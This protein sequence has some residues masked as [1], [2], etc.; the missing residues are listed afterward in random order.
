MK[1]KYPE[2][3]LRIAYEGLYQ[4][5]DKRF[6]L[7]VDNAN[8]IHFVQGPSRSSLNINRMNKHVKYYVGDT[9]FEM[10]G[11]YIYIYIIKNIIYNKYIDKKSKGGQ[12]D[13]E[14]VV[15]SIFEQSSVNEDDEIL[16]F[17]GAWLPYFDYELIR[18]EKPKAVPQ[19]RHWTD[20]ECGKKIR[21]IPPYIYRY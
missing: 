2:F 14:N 12:V 8:F 3:K 5:T 11:I 9:K 1:Q 21:L 18:D 10:F 15:K 16:L 7:L 20:R 17:I 4:E 13:R 6:K 19:H